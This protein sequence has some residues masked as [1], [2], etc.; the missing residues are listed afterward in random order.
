MLPSDRGS[1]VSDCVA[2]GCSIGTTYFKVLR[3]SHRRHW[4]KS[5]LHSSSQT[6]TLVT[7]LVVIEV[8][9]KVFAATS[10]TNTGTGILLYTGFEDGTGTLA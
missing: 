1:K 2:S 7:K 6:S 4:G 5:T 3:L 9:G 8:T 10:S